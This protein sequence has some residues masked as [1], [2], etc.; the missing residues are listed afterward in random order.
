MEMAAASEK[1]LHLVPMFNCGET[2]IL[3]NLQ[4][5]KR[6]QKASVKALRANVFFFPYGRFGLL[7]VPRP[8]DLTTLVAKPILVPRIEKPTKEQVNLLHERYMTAIREAFERFSDEADYSRKT[9]V[10]EP[11]V[12]RV[13]EEEWEVAKASFEEV[14]LT[15]RDTL[16][17][18]YSTKGGDRLEMTA[19]AIW[20]M[21]IFTY[22]FVRCLKY[23]EKFVLDTI[24]DTV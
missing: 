15:T 8:R 11:E 6:W 7:G 18:L 23:T 20:W 24:F 13:T 1:P 4:V 10:F 19:T 22:I 21:G 5:P 9:L 16:E 17:E 2:E 12:N 14:P 3:D